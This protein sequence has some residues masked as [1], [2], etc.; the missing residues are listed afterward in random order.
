M[1]TIFITT[2]TVTAFTGLLAFLLTLADRTIGDYGQ[3]KLT[4][5]ENREYIV[6]GGNSLL[7]TLIEQ[8][9]FIPSA[10]G[11]KGTC[12]YCKVKVLEGGGPVLSTELPWLTEEEVENNIRLSCQCKIKENIKIEIPEE[13]FNVR[14]YE[15]TVEFIEDLTPTIKRLRLRLKEG[16]EINFKPG[17]YIQLK[18]PIYEG[19]DEEVY[20]AYSIAS[21][22]SEKNY[23]DLII[24]YVPGGIATTYVHKYLK[25]GDTV[26]INGPYGNF[27]Y[28]DNYKNEMIL[29]AVGT[30]MAPILSILYYMKENN[31][32]R[33]AR[34]YFGARTP[35]DLFLLDVMEDFEK[36]L[37]DFK[38]V[39]TLSRVLDE[40]NWT[41]ERGRV[42]VV[43]DRHIK[44]P[45]DKE[46]YLCGSP[47]MI[48][49]VVGLLKEKG[50]LEEYIYYD[51]F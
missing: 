2:I 18:A 29:V 28:Q 10:C 11:G 32:K 27:Y 49:T 7:S 3:V 50:I 48:D 1:E 45:E 9:I 39:P 12:G 35:E 34:F 40:H 15:T 51:K 24:G 30:G 6:D 13:L 8:K 38:F 25:A 17:Q 23:L 22:P 37:Y 47:G 14:E 19:N 31:I 43:L 26:H 4:I 20:R 5:N 21:P 46:A 36:T 44:S 16:E 33:K 42:N 41:G